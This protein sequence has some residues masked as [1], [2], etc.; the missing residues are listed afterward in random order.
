MGNN[1]NVLN[2]CCVQCSSRSNISQRDIMKK[3]LTAS[4]MTESFSKMYD[5]KR[6]NKIKEITKNKKLNSS[7]YF[8]HD[9]VLIGKKIGNPTDKYKIEE[10]IEKGKNNTLIYKASLKSNGEKRVLKIIQK[11]NKYLNETKELIKEIDFLEETDNPYIVKLYE[12]Y[13]CPKVICLVNEYCNGGNLNDKLKEE[14]QLS[15]LTTSFIIFQILSALSYCHNKKIIHRNLTLS[16]ILIDNSKKYNYI[17]IKLIDF[18]SSAKLINGSEMGDSVGNLKYI[19]PEVFTGKYNESRDIWSVGI[20]MYKLL[21]GVFPFENQN[22]LKLK[23]LIEIS[24]VDYEKYPLNKV[25]KECIDL[26]QKLLKKDKGRI[27]AKDALNHIWFKKLQIKEKINYLSFDK[28]KK[29]LDNIFQFKANKTLQKLCLSYLTR[30]SKN[31]EIDDA[32]NLFCQI[33]VDNDGEVE[34]NEFVFNLKK[35]IL[36]YEKYVDEN[37][38]RNLFNN[39]DIDQSGNISYSEFISAAID[40]KLILT[41]DNLVESFEFFDKNKDGFI[42]AEDLNIIFT[43]FKDFSTE[44][45]YE[46]FKE[47]DI[48]GNGEINFEEYN[49]IMKSI[50]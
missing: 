23:A 1:V 9:S 18:S 34:E 17:H 22:I 15:E 35:I 39:I 31:E 25:N 2:I 6:N 24:N 28:I 30:K 26:L 5:T 45:F 8:L 48:D 38:L 44:D 42:S 10:L 50:E 33:D 7:L 27:N 49:Q 12:F 43:K 3:P 13:D 37:Y 21:T 11:N 32:T 4:E 19:S 29:I 16:N 41:D 46:I 47:V 20:I 14:K 40:K 36:K